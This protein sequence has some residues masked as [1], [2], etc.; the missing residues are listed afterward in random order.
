MGPQVSQQV[1]PQQHPQQHPIRRHMVSTPGYSPM[2]GDGSY[3]ANPSPYS[4]I[5]HPSMPP[6]TAGGMPR[7][8]S[9]PGM[10]NSPSVHSRM[11]NPN[12]MYP[13]PGQHPS[14]VNPYSSYYAPGTPDH[15]RLPSYSSQISNY[16][17]PRPPVQE[18][19]KKVSKKAPQAR[20]ASQKLAAL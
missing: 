20:S 15:S 9:H 17:S 7:M 2:P 18:E 13:Y 3:Q 8:Q 14:Q 16:S 12:N 19:V 6:T 5:P 4:R 10:S 11:P 1:T